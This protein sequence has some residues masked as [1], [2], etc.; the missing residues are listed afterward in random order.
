MSYSRHS[1][2][3]CVKMCLRSV[4]YSPHS[5]QPKFIRRFQLPNRRMIQ[6][7]ILPAIKKLQTLHVVIQ[8]HVIMR[9]L[10]LRCNQK[11]FLILIQQHSLFQSFN[12]PKTVLLIFHS[13]LL[14]IRITELYI[15]IPTQTLLG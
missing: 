4:R 9:L 7:H 13:I 2:F 6:E 8:N 11:N 14:G 15:K 3:Q 1:F 5:N 10:S 12:L